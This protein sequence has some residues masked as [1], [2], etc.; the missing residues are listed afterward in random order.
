LLDAR[1][2]KLFSV[3][4]CRVRSNISISLYGCAASAAA[5]SNTGGLR[6]VAERRKFSLP[7]GTTCIFANYSPP[8]AAGHETWRIENLNGRRQSQGY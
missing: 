3:G 5:S 4:A 1:A 2:K 6:K 7:A 8:L